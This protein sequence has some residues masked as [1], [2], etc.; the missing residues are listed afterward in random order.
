MKKV[1]IVGTLVV[2]VLACKKEA[3]SSDSASTKVDT[4]I[5]AEGK[6]ASYAYGINLGI[7]TE[8]AQGQ[9]GQDSIDYA[10]M[11]KGIYDFLKDPKGQNSYSYGLNIGNQ[12]QAAL[13]NKMLK[14]NLDQDEI[15]LGMMD[16]LDKKDLR[17]SK[18]SVQ[19]VMQRFYQNLMLKS[20]E[21]NTRKSEAFMDSISKAEGV[22]VL[23]SGLAY[24]IITSSEGE[25][26]ELGDRIKVKYTGKTI[27]GEVFDSTDKNNKGEAIEFVLQEG[28]LIQGWVEGVQLMSKGGKYELY[29]PADLA[30][31]ESGSGDIEPNEAL[32]F[33]M[34]LIDVTKGE[35]K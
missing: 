10:E 3:G 7:G 31:G 6:E 21:E 14:G 18:D 13:E 23:P 29:I 34:E 30:Y 5:T 11:K 33:E 24:K 20:G 35:K 25:K 17:V 19:L 16:Y 2:S 15:I 32:I 9:P 4:E 22:T 27:D 8:M 1:F 26:P 28:S 12:I